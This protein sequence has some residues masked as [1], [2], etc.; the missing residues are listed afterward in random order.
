[1]VSHSPQKSPFP[2]LAASSVRSLH[3]FLGQILSSKERIIIF[4]PNNHGALPI[5]VTSGDV[6]IH[7][8]VHSAKNGSDQ[9]RKSASAAK[10]WNRSVVPTEKPS[11][12]SGCKRRK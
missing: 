1:M 8:V 5:R 9:W 11:R 10:V 12:R 7:K 2:S 4:L 6:I 3:K